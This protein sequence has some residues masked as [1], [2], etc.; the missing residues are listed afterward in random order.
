MPIDNA[1][2]NDEAHR[3]TPRQREVL[4]VMAKGLTNREIGEVLGISTGTVRVHVAAILESLGVANRTEATNAYHEMGLGAP[5]GAPTVTGRPALAVLP[6]ASFSEEADAI[7]LADGISEDLIT[8]LARWR[9]F[10][11]VSRNSSFA[12]RGRSVDA[13]EIGRALGARYLVEGSVRTA[14]DQVRVTV[15]L[16]DSE[17]GRHLWAQHYDRASGHRFDVQDE[18]VDTIVAT[19]EPSLL[20]IG[21]LRIVEG[22]AESRDAWDRVQTAFAHLARNDVT[23]LQEGARLAEEAVALDSRLAVAYGA[24][25]YG[26]LH[27]HLLSRAT[28]GAVPAEKLASAS[29]ALEALDPLEPLAPVGRAI[30]QL[31]R[32]EKE[33]ALAS[34]ERAVELAPRMI[35]PLWLRALLLTSAGRPEASIEAH[36]DLEA[37]APE[38]PLQPM[39]RTTHGIALLMSGRIDAAEDVFEAAI[40]AAPRLVYARTMLAAGR[41]IVGDEAGM[42]RRFAEIRGIDPDYDPRVPADVMLPDSVRAAGTAFLASAGWPA[43]PGDPV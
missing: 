9:W 30:A 5:A 13:T 39:I 34:V 33:A 28:D 7:H 1:S 27:L 40:E 14:G 35:Y 29:R 17:S 6:L 25:F 4:E 10:P 26:Q 42:L 2:A 22:D 38:D 43:R 20:Q 12:Y 19:L 36:R 32:L 23:G 3:L 31:V 41:G 8:R 16:I 18:I 21:G 24:V 11:V 15:Q 37:L